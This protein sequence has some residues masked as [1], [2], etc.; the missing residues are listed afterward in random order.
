[1]N[2]T[3]VALS[4]GAPP[5]AIGV[6][7]LSGPHALAAAT[8]LAGSLPP[9][10]EARVRRLS[11]NGA[12]LDHALVLIFPAPDTAT[13]EDLVELHAHGGPAVIDAIIAALLTQPGV[14]SA[15][16]G[17]FTRRALTNGRID[18]TQ[19]EALAALLS[20]QSQA[21]HRAAILAADGVLRRNIDD[22]ESRLLALSARIELMLDF[23]DEE[24]AANDAAQLA[25]VRHGVDAL[26]AEVEAWL[27]YPTVD[28]LHNG[29]RIVLAGPPNA[30]K[31][32]LLNSLVGRQAAIVSDIAG[33]TR[34]R[35]E[36]PVVH[37][38]VQFLLTDTAGLAEATSD[39]VEAIGI[40]RAAAAIDAADLVLWLGDSPP[41]RPE[42]LWLLPRADLPGRKDASGERLTVSAKAGVGLDALWQ[43]IHERIRGRLP[44]EDGRAL[45]RRQRDCMVAVH[46][47]LICA[48]SSADPLL[49]AHHLSEARRNL[50]RLTGRSDT[51]SMLDALFERFCIGK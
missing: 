18:L 4:S 23:A 19:A 16:P 15:E 35:I 9:A 37:N 20:A 47:N 21:Q 7:R 22:F 44:P 24:D 31:S 49:I 2:D 36:V 41:S 40:E 10:R 17:E 30:G 26:A 8:A 29:F 32:T 12:L 42:M 33:T 6:I 5:A 50:H 13:G 39:P 48:G 1:M 11:H 28:A 38:G 43:A 3:I 46:R 45:N 25:A 51:E 27:A 34:D 14:R